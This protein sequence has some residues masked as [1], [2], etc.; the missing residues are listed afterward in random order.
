MTDYTKRTKP[1][2]SYTERTAIIW[3]ESWENMTMTWAEATKS[4]KHYFD[5]SIRRSGITTS[6]TER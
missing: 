5:K 2:T 4:W 6:W 3:K 1:T